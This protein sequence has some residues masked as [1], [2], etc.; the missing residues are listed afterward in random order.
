LKLLWK[1]SWLPDPSLWPTPDIKHTHSWES[2]V[3]FSTSKH[4]QEDLDNA[5]VAVLNITIRWKHKTKDD[6]DSQPGTVKVQVVKTWADTRAQSL[7]NLLK[8]IQLG[9]NPNSLNILLT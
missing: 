7:S 1:P 6:L 2:T 4:H 5:F 3:V 9:C 8:D